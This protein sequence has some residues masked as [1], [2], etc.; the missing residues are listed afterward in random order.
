MG[1]KLYVGNL[2]YTAAEQAA[3]WETYINQ[4]EYLSSRR[5]QYA[6]RGGVLLPMVWRLDFAVAQDLFKDLGT[7]RHSLQFR[8]DFLNF[9]NLLSS[10]WG[11]GQRLVQNQVLVSRG[12]DTQG[13][14]SYQMRVVNNQLLTKSL[15]STANEAD[16][17]RIQFSLRY[18]FN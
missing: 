12:A 9:S 1:R 18:S 4:D 3:A 16:V 13:R 2:P 11:V 7:N 5:G 14:A 6:E 10:D 17:Y 8:A 15:E